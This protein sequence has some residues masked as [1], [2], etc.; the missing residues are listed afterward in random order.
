MAQP[1]SLKDNPLSVFA[2]TTEPV[3]CIEGEKC[4][5][6]PSQSFD[7]K[8]KCN[9]CRL[10]PGA[11]YFVR[12]E[13]WK[14]V[15]PKF[16]HR[17]LEEEKRHAKREATIV[18]AEA[19]KA[20]D[21][22]KQARLRAAERAERKT[23]ARIIK[24]TRNSGRVNRDGDSL[25]FDSVVVDTKLQSTAADPVIHLKELDKVRADARRNGKLC[26]ALCL[27]NKTGRSIIVVDGADFAAITRRLNLGQEAPE[28]KPT[29]GP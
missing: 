10:S 25:L 15:N 17:K 16:K 4:L 28:S 29:V 27:Q 8:S 2:I 19:R 18:R 5:N 12:T 24:A 6:S 7:H 14:P 22:T 13:H 26:G 23:N 9:D 20:K 11:P 3:A 1:E 21:P